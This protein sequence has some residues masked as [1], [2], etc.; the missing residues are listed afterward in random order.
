MKTKQQTIIEYAKSVNGVLLDKMVETGIRGGL[1]TY[2][3]R[4][5]RRKI[6]VALWHDTQK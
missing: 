6:Q 2:W 4:S 5:D 1:K 3:R